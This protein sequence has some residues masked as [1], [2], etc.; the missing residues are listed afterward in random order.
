MLSIPVPF[1]V[2]LLLIIAA[3]LLFL[4]LGKSG[5]K[6]VWF[7]IL[8]ATCTFVVGMRWT[9]DL[10]WVRF[11][12]PILASMLPIAAWYCF[13]KA[14]HNKRPAFW[15]IGWPILIAVCSF[16]YAQWPFATDMALIAL[17]LGYGGALI[18]SSLTV[19]EEVRLSN[20]QR[21]VVAERVAG[22]MLLFSA[23]IDSMLS[24]DFAFYRGEHGPAI[25]S[26]SYLILI[27]M[28]VG[29]VAIVGF[30]TS[31]RDR[32]NNAAMPRSTPMPFPSSLDADGSEIVDVTATNPSPENHAQVSEE[33]S[34]DIMAKFDG[35]MHIKQTYRDPDIT[36]SRLSRKLG[37][38][39]KQL[40][41]AVNK[42]KGENISKVINAYRIEHAKTLLETTKDSITEI[43]LA[44]GFQT[45]SNF[46]REFLRIT[47][48][49][50]SAYRQSLQ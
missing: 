40:S 28:V 38:P 6:S 8:C 10:Q 45:K 23:S 15:H 20:V 1:V 3:A 11:V 46:N 19:P 21:V 49:T 24:F 43:Y 25:I 48:Q 39:A 18:A 47:G 26:L 36:L 5:Q 12:Q 17:Y 14:H 34:A 42:C 33:E 41:S 22:S 27:P 13:A 9:L 50:P 31:T 29:A 30:S 37:I 16:N 44:S 7:T 2:S 4:T 32:D 35:L